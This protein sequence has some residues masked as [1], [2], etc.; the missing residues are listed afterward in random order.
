ML[1]VNL[2]AFGSSTCVWFIYMRLDHLHAF[3]SFIC[4]WIIYMR[5][6]HLRMFSLLTITPVY[7]NLH[8]VLQIC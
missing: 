4:V 6:V 7:I 8:A 3:G 5:L 1:L 2:H